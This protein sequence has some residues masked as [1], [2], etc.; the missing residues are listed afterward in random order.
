MKV[1]QGHSASPGLV[2]GQECE[3]HRDVDRVAVGGTGSAPCEAIHVG[4]RER[5][6]G[7]PPGAGGCGG[8]G[9]GG[10]PQLL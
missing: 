4:V 5:P 2:L 7:G 9:W 6:E 8:R 1:Y 10:R 3:P